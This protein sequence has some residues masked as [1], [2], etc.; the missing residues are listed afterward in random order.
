M[1]F[2]TMPFHTISLRSTP[3]EM[4]TSEKPRKTTRSPRSNLQRREPDPGLGLGHWPKSV[5]IVGKGGKKWEKVGKRW[6]NHRSSNP[7]I[8]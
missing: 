6:E 4:P 3:D 2:H 8:E 1:P 5:R 7:K